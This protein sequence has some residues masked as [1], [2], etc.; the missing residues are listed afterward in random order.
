MYFNRRVFESNAVPT[1]L[2][3]IIFNAIVFQ[4]LCGQYVIRCRNYINNIEII[5]SSIFD[6]ANDKKALYKLPRCINT[7]YCIG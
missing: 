7:E 5:A 3:D 2:L 4:K 1:M 6:T